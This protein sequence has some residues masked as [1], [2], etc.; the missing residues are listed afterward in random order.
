MLRLNKKIRGFLRI[1]CPCSSYL[2]CFYRDIPFRSHDGAA[3]EDCP[4][5]IRR[6]ISQMILIHLRD[7]VIVE[8][9]SIHFI[10]LA[11]KHIIFYTVTPQIGHIQHG[12]EPVIGQQIVFRLSYIVD[13]NRR[14]GVCKH[15]ILLQMKRREYIYHIVETSAIVFV[16][17]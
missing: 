17:Q 7:K 1:E 8:T 11:A 14:E 13:K 9:G 3:R 6:Y 15:N 2:V 5:L 16:L 10:C 4:V 12:D